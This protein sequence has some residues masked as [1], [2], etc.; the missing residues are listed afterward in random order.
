MPF[1]LNNRY[2]TTEVGPPGR[3]VVGSR[4]LPVTIQSRERCECVSNMC[5][6]HLASQNLVLYI[7]VGEQPMR[8]ISIRTLMVVVIMSAI[9]LAALRNADDT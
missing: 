4:S 7:R 6:S 1:R 3:P 5:P 2:N 8:R 9:F